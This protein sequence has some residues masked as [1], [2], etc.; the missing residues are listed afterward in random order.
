ML[1]VLSW[2]HIDTHRHTLTHNKCF[3]SGVS[4]YTD[5]G[6][7]VSDL[8]YLTAGQAADILHV[9]PWRITQACRSGALTA[10]K[11]GQAWLIRPADLTAYVDAHRKDAA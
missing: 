1:T 8:T 11:V 6:K 4:Y 5:R 7:T 9:T 2:A 3:G 10:V